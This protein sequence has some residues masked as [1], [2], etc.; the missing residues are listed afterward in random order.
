M[1]PKI[2]II[3]VHYQN[4]KVLFNC[5]NSIKKNLSIK[6]EVIV[7]DNDEE[8]SIK[9]ELLKKYPS[10]IYLKAP[11]NI[12]F[13]AGCNLGAKKAQSNYLFF[14]N[15]D[16]TL[17]KNS[18]KPMVDYLNTHPKVK[19][20]APVLLNKREKPYPIQGT[21][22]LTPVKAIFSLSFI[23]KLLPN[24]NISNSYWINV[25]GQTKPIKAEVL[26]G[27]A[28]I[29]RKAIFKRNKGFDKNYFLYFEEVDLEYRMKKQGLRRVIIRGP[30][31]VHLDGGS[32][33]RAKDIRDSFS[34]KNLYYFDSQFRY[35]R[36]NLAARWVVCFLK[37]QLLIRVCNPLFLLS[38]IDKRIISKIVSI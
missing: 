35:L 24:N 15:P 7:V 30:R 14:L 5:L 25:I 23:N 33:P 18:V 34:L 32:S 22:T 17:L 6:Y 31:I 37:I 20:V 9:N 16:T 2:S 19:A 38:N 21:T 26:P 1:K 3:T 8:G 13:G 27:S 29:I 10:V 11:G 12:G 4:K 36:I 28:F